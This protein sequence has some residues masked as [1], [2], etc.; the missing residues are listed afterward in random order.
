[1]FAASL[2]LTKQYISNSQPGMVLCLSG[3]LQC[4]E[5]LETVSILTMGGWCVCRNGGVLTALR[6]RVQRYNQTSS[7]AQDDLLASLTYSYSL[8][9]VFSIFFPSRILGHLAKRVDP[10]IT[11]SYIA[12]S[13][14]SAKAKKPCITLNSMA[15]QLNS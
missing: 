4:Q 10:K 5:N 11:K 2:Y 9:T 1:M 13:F 7:S 15:T 14:N 3:H 6:G 8:G 12:Q